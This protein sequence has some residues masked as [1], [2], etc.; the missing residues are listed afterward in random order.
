MTWDC[1]DRL[2]GGLRG[3]LRARLGLPTGAENW[4]L[5]ASRWEFLTPRDRFGPTHHVY[6]RVYGSG[7][8]L[9]VLVAP[10]LGPGDAVF[11]VGWARN[12]YWAVRVW[13]F[14]GSGFR[15]DFDADAAGTDEPSLAADSW[16]HPLGYA[17]TI[18][19]AKR[20]RRHRVMATPSYRLT[21]GGFTSHEVW[22]APRV[23]F[24]YAN[25]NPEPEETPV[26][27]EL[28]L[29]GP[30][31]EQHLAEVRAIPRENGFGG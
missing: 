16:P 26:A 19:C 3:W 27:I 13:G 14:D 29:G 30:R 31:W 2:V 4:L 11:A 25:P 28:R 23:R 20:L 9:Y 24:H 22:A 18:A 17:E 21:D 8:G 1:K 15:N 12:D 6:G 7:R 10:H 5:A